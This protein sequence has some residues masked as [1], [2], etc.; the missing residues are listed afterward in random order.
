VKKITT[1]TKHNWFIGLVKNVI[2]IFKKKHQ[3]I[4][5]KKSLP[6]TAIFITNHEG[7]SGPI[8]LNIF[9]PKI[10]VPW[11]A[12]QMMS[13][14]I[15]RWKYLYHVFYRKKL[16]YGKFISFILASIFGLVSKIIYNGVFLIATFPDWR[17]RKTIQESLEHLHHHNSIVVF[18]E[19]SSGGYLDEIEAFHSGFVYLAQQFFYKNGKHIPIIPLYYHRK[20]CQIIIGKAYTLADFP[21][22]EN[23]K[24]IAERF[25][26]IL[27]QLTE[28][29][30]LAI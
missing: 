24:Q 12:H 21:A 23:R 1:I 10:L 22:S 9:F 16:K 11:G 27:N 7:A 4:G 2:K 18:P 17:V 19:D 25:R 13:N 5:S 15:S 26:I 28:S 30:P 8:T 6:E 3:I 29:K 20:K 14:Y